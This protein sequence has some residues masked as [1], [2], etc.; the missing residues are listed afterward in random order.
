MNFPVFFQLVVFPNN[1]Q[2]LYEYLPLSI[3]Y[4][5]FKVNLFSCDLPFLAVNPQYF[6]EYHRLCPNTLFPYHLTY[7]LIKLFLSLAIVSVNCHLDMIDFYCYNLFRFVC[8][9]RNFRGTYDI[10]V[11]LYLFIYPFFN[12]QCA[13]SIS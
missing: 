12:V 5:Y 2:F 6:N 3:N 1:P 11:N 7:F 9:L 10:L 8:T 4:L 13:S